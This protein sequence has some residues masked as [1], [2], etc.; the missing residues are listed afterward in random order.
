MKESDQRHHPAVR[1][2][3][4]GLLDSAQTRNP[5]VIEMRSCYLG[6]QLRDPSFLTEVH[7]QL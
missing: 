2:Y 1:T 5:K 7:V 4:G 6:G 3:L